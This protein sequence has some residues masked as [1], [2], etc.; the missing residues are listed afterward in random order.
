MEPYCT[1]NVNSAADP[2]WQRPPGMPPG[3]KI[4]RDPFIWS[5]SES[6]FHGTK[7]SGGATGINGVLVYRINSNARLVIYFENPWSWWPYAG[8]CIDTSNKVTA[9]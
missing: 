1:K 9:N 4:N 8:V 5:F 6:N 3:V 2:N 7:K